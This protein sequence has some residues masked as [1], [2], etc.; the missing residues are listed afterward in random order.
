MERG[1]DVI[2]EIL[3][4]ALISTVNAAEVGSKLAE[5]GAPEDDIAA[6]IEALHVSIVPFEKRHFLRAASLRPITKR[7]GLSLG[8][9]ACLATAE[10][11]G[12]VAVTADRAWSKLKLPVKVQMVR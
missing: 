5:E 8:A 3:D 11:L 2:A 1:R 6:V 7:A 4:D 9:R 10:L 12:A